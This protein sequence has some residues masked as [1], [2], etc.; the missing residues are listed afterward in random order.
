MLQTVQQQ[1]ARLH[2]EGRNNAT[3]SEPLRIGVVYHICYQNAVTSDSSQDIADSISKLNRD[4]ALTSSNYDCGAGIYQG[5]LEEVYSEY[6]ETAQDCKVEFYLVET[7]YRRM[8]PVYTNNISVI[9]RTIKRFSPAVSP[10]K[11]L[12]IWVPTMN[13]G[14][15]GYA[16]FPWNDEPSTDGV[17]IAQSTFGRNPSATDYDL[18]KT[19]THEIGHWLGLYHTFQETHQYQGGNIDYAEGDNP[20]EMRGDCVVDTPTQLQPTYGSPLDNPAAW[21]RSVI[22]DKQTNYHMYMNF[23]DYTN[24]DNMFMFTRDQ[25]EKIHLMLGWLL[26]PQNLIFLDSTQGISSHCL[27][28]FRNPFILATN[29]FMI[30]STSLASSSSGSSASL[31]YTITTSP[32]E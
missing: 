21:P 6:L 24:D 4:F 5:R 30:V 17:L 13:N 18:G 3:P 32:P 16:Q 15:L 9:D 12:N 8:P 29:T 20:E 22:S 11:Y 2:A 1:Q 27:R 25:V 31:W 10:Q 28:Y 19:L 7:K 26:V 23:M 14:L